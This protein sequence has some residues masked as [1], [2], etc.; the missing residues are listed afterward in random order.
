MADNELL[1]MYKQHSVGQDNYTYFLLAAAAAAIGFGINKTD[2][3]K[4]TYW[5]LPVAISI[6][7]WAISFFFGCRAIY[8][9]QASLGANYSYVQL[10][11]GAHPKQPT[12]PIG[13]QQAMQGVQHAISHNRGKAQFYANWQFNILIIG[14]IF[15][16]LW[17]ILEMIRITFKA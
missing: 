8:W 4:L 14:F 12:D 6:V 9:V 3:S 2:G 11:Y 5:L 15:F 7:C 16:L 13:A 1:E 17:R 10:R